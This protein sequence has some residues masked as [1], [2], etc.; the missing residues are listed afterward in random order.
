MRFVGGLKYWRGGVGRRRASAR[1]QGHTTLE[2]CSLPLPRPAGVGPGGSAASDFE[3]FTSLAPIEFWSGTCEVKTVTPCPACQKLCKVGLGS[4]GPRR[5]GGAPRSA[6]NSPCI[7]LRVQGAQGLEDHLRTKHP[8]LTSLLPFNSKGFI[9]HE[10]RACASCGRIFTSLQGAS[11]HAAATGHVL[12]GPGQVPPVPVPPPASGALWTPPAPFEE[13]HLLQALACSAPPPPVPPAA[14]APRPAPPPRPSDDTSAAMQL[15]LT[16]DH[17]RIA[18]LTQAIHDAVGSLA[19]LET[20]AWGGRD[21]VRTTA[22]QARAA[23][24]LALATA[25]PQQDTSLDR[26]SLRPRPSR[27]SEEWAI[28][29]PVSAYS[30][31]AA[32]RAPRPAKEALAQH[33]WAVLANSV[34]PRER[35]SWDAARPAQAPPA[36]PADMDTWGVMMALY[37]SA[38]MGSN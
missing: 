15:Q 16:I 12:L 33:P 8:E 20:G 32:P 10:H 19:V 25:S 27:P 14:P 36:L 11:D 29:E 30:E 18:G 9:T 17:L 31:R 2:T 38:G 13:Q 34:A 1:R 3:T 24:Q 23:L 35:S 7:L 5:S 26:A 37:N 4:L 6:N 21:E 22:A 28:T